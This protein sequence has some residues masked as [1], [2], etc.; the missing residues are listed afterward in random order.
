MSY[1]QFF[2]ILKEA[3]QRGLDMSYQEAVLDF[4]DG[5]TSSL[6]DLAPWELQELQRNLRLFSRGDRTPGDK[7]DTMRK[8]II[9]IFKSIGK[10]VAAAKAWA[11]KYG[12]KGVK[13][14]FN[15]YTAQELYVLI[16]NAEKM[17]R[18]F[19]TALNRS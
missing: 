17:K 5:R 12:V 6:K 7:T 8:A 13:R 1:A 11:E 9:A 10:D 18:D 14:G 2:A 19:I 4:T 3:N 16:R 15:D